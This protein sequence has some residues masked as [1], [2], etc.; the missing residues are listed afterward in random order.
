MSHGH[1]DDT[2][3]DI[4]NIYSNREYQI[5]NASAPMA[6]IPGSQQYPLYQSITMDYQ[7]QYAIPVMV[8]IPVQVGREQMSKSS[9]EGRSH[10]KQ[11]MAYS[12]TADNLDY[13]I[14]RRGEQKVRRYRS[15][16]ESK[17]LG[18]ISDSSVS[19]YRSK[20]NSSVTS[21]EDTSS[22]DSSSSSSSQE[23]R[24]KNPFRKRRS[25]SISPRKIK[26]NPFRKKGTTSKSYGKKSDN[27]F[28]KRR[29]EKDDLGSVKT[30]LRKSKR[31]Q[32][33]PFAVK[34]N[35]HSRSPNRNRKYEAERRKR[36]WPEGNGEEK[37]Q[38]QRSF[39]RQKSRSPYSPEYPR[40]SY[41]KVARRE[42]NRYERYEQVEKH[43]WSPAS[44]PGRKLHRPSVEKYQRTDRFDEV[45][46]S[47]KNYEKNFYDHSVTSKQDIRHVR[48]RRQSYSPFSDSSS[49]D[50][51]AGLKIHISKRG[52]WIENNRKIVPG[53]SKGPLL[54]EDGILIKPG[55][56]PRRK[57]V[58]QRSGQTRYIENDIE[59][60]YDDRSRE[61]KRSWNAKFEMEDVSDNESYDSQRFRRF[62][63]FSAPHVDSRLSV[64]KTSSV[65][66]GHASYTDDIPFDHFN[67]V[68]TVSDRLSVQNICIDY[69]LDK[70]VCGSACRY[71]HLCKY[72]ILGVC[73]YGD[74][75]NKSHD[76][77]GPQS[78]SLL[79]KQ[80]PRIERTEYVA[81]KV[82][83]ILCA[84]FSRN[85][86]MPN[87]HLMEKSQ[88][89]GKEKRSPSVES[90]K[91][92]ESIE[93][94]DSFDARYYRAG[95][96]VKKAKM[97]KD[98]KSEEVVCP[99]IE[100]SKKEEKLT[101]ALNKSEKVKTQS[102]N[103]EKNIVKRE[104][105]EMTSES[106]E[107]KKEENAFT[108]AASDI[109]DY[110]GK[111]KMETESKQEVK[112]EKKV[113]CD[114]IDVSEQEKDLS[115]SVEDVKSL[116]NLDAETKVSTDSKHVDVQKGGTEQQAGSV[117]KDE[118]RSLSPVS[119]ENIE[120]W[121]KLDKYERISD[122]GM[123]DEEKVKIV[124]DE[125]LESVSSS[126]SAVESKRVI[127]LG[128]GAV[129]KVPIQIG[130]NDP[131]IFNKSSR[132][133]ETRLES[134]IPVEPHLMPKTDSLIPNI[135]PTRFPPIDL[136]VPPPMLPMQPPHL[137]S[138]VVPH[139]RPPHPLRPPHPQRPPHPHFNP[140][141]RPV[142][143]INVHRP[144]FRP[145]FPHPGP[146][147]HDPQNLS[148]IN[149]SQSMN[150]HAR[151]FHPD[152]Q[153]P[154]PLR[155]NSGQAMP[156][157]PMIPNIGQPPPIRP[158]GPPPPAFR[159]MIPEV[160]HIVPNVP[161][162]FNPPVQLTNRLPSPDLMKE[163]SKTLA[164]KHASKNEESEHKDTFQSESEKKMMGVQ[165]SDADLKEPM[166]KLWQFPHKGI[167]NMSIIEFVTETEVY[168]DEMVAEM[169]KILVTINLPYVTLK[170]LMSVIKEKIQINLNTPADLRKIL[171]MY[172]DNFQIIE[173]I[174]SDDESDGG[175]IKKNVQIK[176][177][178]KLGFCSK[179]GYLPFYVGKCE[180]KQLHLCKFYFL[181][182]CPNMN[183]KFGH[184]LRT[185]HNINTLKHHRLH[186]MTGEEIIEFICDIDSRT[187]ETIPGVC[188]FYN[189]SLNQE[190]GCYKGNV[191]D[192][193]DIC[194]N[195]H[196]CFYYVKNKCL[197]QN[198]KRSH[199]IRDTQP[200]SLLKKYGLDPD[201][202]GET[203]ILDLIAL[204]TVDVKK[205]KME[206]A[207][208]F[209][210]GQKSLTEEFRKGSASQ[211]RDEDPKAHEESLLANTMGKEAKKRKKPSIKFP[212]VCK[213]F[214]NPTGC[215]K[216]DWGPA[217][218]CLFLHVCQKFV[219]GQCQLGQKCKR[220]HSFFTGESAA[221]IA[222]YGID[223]TRL[224][225]QEILD[226]LNENENALTDLPMIGDD[227][228]SEEESK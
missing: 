177:R 61:R 70:P 20:S 125:D 150:I 93:S 83:E 216:K 195:L 143:P 37:V 133:T 206:T 78:F 25:R 142:Q 144:P 111:P 46:D 108:C 171:E 211:K 75:C 184:K 186:R 89:I 179:H 181:S 202:F 41:S 151:P 146:V 213:F 96:D 204:K 23:R 176:P 153:Q 224:S 180:C 102:V 10:G 51:G 149:Q 141:V 67:K 36:K 29:S 11:P 127:D 84:R 155:P 167:I 27:P 136:T 198:C 71:L 5:R 59:V 226:T 58:P 157:R 9:N 159:P 52:R 220:S 214:N 134:D 225:E 107:I 152:F 81:N 140:H 104:N 94:I 138:N 80:N 158:V 173:T 109:S 100:Q 222:R 31:R 63:D 72:F 209:Q 156:P 221:L 82:K 60:F 194:H 69:N 218:Y 139:V 106:V 49:N 19:S 122:D 115:Y 18:E 79:R 8:Q 87:A 92:E 210:S 26:E 99:K 35:R 113:Q 77:L 42:S 16:S 120:D 90:I 76:I 174:D 74:T 14:H 166:K 137:Q 101:D 116:K 182:H 196:L 91:S 12:S 175:E 185:E 50:S 55:D 135:H 57:S 64:T 117:E 43:Q 197:V 164:K 219:D 47:R 21:S 148:N 54:M 44:S 48:Q 132:A 191:T 123:S 68:R 32:T 3:R 205:R 178:V 212:S 56:E 62:R 6:Y 22:S 207:Q 24:P 170:K 162:T 228:D 53:P 165:R 200:Y 168:K 110:I 190:S 38:R 119:V 86:F 66:S 147:H 114:K 217:G 28:R 45:R 189:S 124:A 73:K 203:R 7:S 154:R 187:I 215:K 121:D 161:H 128:T 199:S 188:K 129:N 160:R 40:D 65:W 145:G 130:M 34:S 105:T 126:E 163:A 227:E 97:D 15:R 2:G 98:T 95:A 33:S 118:S 131:L 193:Q 1:Y 17:S 30:S 223:L 112:I 192:F 39:S 85:K 183:C 4:C 201:K 103:D 208:Q 172:P 169:V 13:F 88:Q